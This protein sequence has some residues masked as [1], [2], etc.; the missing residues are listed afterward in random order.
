MCPD[1]R[2]TLR[3]DLVNA[4]EAE[5]G[6]D[7]LLA[8]ARTRAIKPVAGATFSVS[9]SSSADES[10]AKVAVSA[11]TFSAGAAGVGDCG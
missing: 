4:N 1:M 5:E 3:L 6:R 9:L 7:R 2:E 11:S 8:A 10:A